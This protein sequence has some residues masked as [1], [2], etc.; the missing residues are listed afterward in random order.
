[1]GTF[2][3]LLALCEGNPP[4]TGG[5]PSH[6]KGQG[7]G[8]LMF[9]L[10]CA[11]NKLLSKHSWGWWF[12]TPSRSLW[13]HCNGQPVAHRPVN[14]DPLH[15]KKYVIPVYF[16][17]TKHYWLPYLTHFGNRKWNACEANISRGYFSGTWH[18]SL[19]KLIMAY[20]TDAP[21]SRWAKICSKLEIT[22][23]QYQCLVIE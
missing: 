13:R 20:L 12:E 21:L 15:A 18:K 23:L 6:H 1:M 5:F 19:P 10:I 3:A 16:S 17:V 7:R 22:Q 8:A 11:L 2:S 9:S 14:C 4:V